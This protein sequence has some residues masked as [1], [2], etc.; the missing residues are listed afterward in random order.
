M[1]NAYARPE[2]LDKPNSPLFWTQD[3]YGLVIEF[4]SALGSRVSIF[5]AC[6]HRARD[7]RLQ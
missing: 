2:Q 6:K 3:G 4:S 1:I 5:E 7:S